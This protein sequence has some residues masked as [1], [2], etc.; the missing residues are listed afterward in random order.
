MGIKKKIKNKVSKS[1]EH[2]HNIT[3]MYFS[4]GGILVAIL[5]GLILF[6]M[7]AFEKKTDIFKFSIDDECSIIMGNLIH[8]IRDGG[9]CKI[10]CMNNC[11]IRELDF[12]DSEFVFENSSCHTCDCYCQ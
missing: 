11:E 7:G 4:I 3:K 10:K 1:G 6:N 8:N 2:N 9:D 12:Y 5:I